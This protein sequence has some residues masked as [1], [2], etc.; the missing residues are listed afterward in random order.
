M[1]IE[2][3]LEM[4]EAALMLD[5]LR[6]VAHKSNNQKIRSV[7][8]NIINEIESDS[9]VAH[10]IL[11]GIRHEFT[12]NNLTNN[13]I[14]PHS[15]MQYGL[16]IPKPFLQEAPGLTRMANFILLKTVKKLKPTVS[17]RKVKKITNTAIKKCAL[18][19]DVINL[20][21]TAYEAA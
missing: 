21:Q 16:G 19:Y 12:T 18:V 2:I 7:L 13:K 1:K 6:N 4:H 15:N 14:F 10:Y 8:G 20:I 3:E 11:N 5:I 9:K 17:T